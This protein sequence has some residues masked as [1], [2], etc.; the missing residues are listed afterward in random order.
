MAEFFGRSEAHDRTLLNHA[1]FYYL[2]LKK[3][4]WEWGSIRDW[5]CILR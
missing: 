1:E 5:K 4:D 3:K 2:F